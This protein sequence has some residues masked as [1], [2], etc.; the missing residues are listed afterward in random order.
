[1]K[2]FTWDAPVIPFQSLAG[3]KLSTP[4][5]V[6]ERGL[7]QCRLGGSDR[8]Q[9]DH[10]P[11]LR[12]EKSGSYVFYVEESFGDYE[13]LDILLFVAVEQ[14]VISCVEARLP[15]VCGEEGVNPV[16]EAVCYKGKWFD[17]GLG[18]GV[19]KIVD[20]CELYYDSADESHVPDSNVGGVSVMT[21]FLANVDMCPDQYVT[22]ISVFKEAINEDWLEGAKEEKKR[23]RESR[24]WKWPGE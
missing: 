10:G 13:S 19:Q 8:F 7:E 16:A 17:C 5:D 23:I 1:M 4:V 12:L 18:E 2:R 14:G 3:I 20:H 15:G 9:F 6:F 22:R 11:V 21:N 24:E